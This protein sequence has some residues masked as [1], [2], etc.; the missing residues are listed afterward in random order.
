MTDA[1]LMAPPSA[2]AS[3][4]SDADSIQPT[5]LD[6]LHSGRLMLV[7]EQRNTVPA[8]DWLKLPSAVQAQALADFQRIVRGNTKAAVIFLRS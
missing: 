2:A 8:D 6:W 5:L 3:R 1:L 4:R 7:D